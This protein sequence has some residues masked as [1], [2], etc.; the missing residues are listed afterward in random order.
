MV[1]EG[2]ILLAAMFTAT[3][4]AF[5]TSAT[6]LCSVASAGQV[7]AEADWLACL[8]PEGFTLDGA[9]HPWGAT[10]ASAWSAFACAWRALAFALTLA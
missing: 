2:V 7:E 9:W 5:G 6:W 1:G 10:F 8:R 3:V 4:T